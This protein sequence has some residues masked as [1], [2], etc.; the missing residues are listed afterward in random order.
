MES[1][2]QRRRERARQLKRR[3]IADAAVQL[4]LKEGLDAATIEAISESADISPRTFFNYFSTKEDALAMGPSVAVDELVAFV[5]A[6]P[7]EEPA[8]R[9]M[10]ALAKH[11]ADSF[12]PSQ[13]QIAL[14]RRYPQ[15]LARAQSGQKD[16][17]FLA[18]MTAV[19]DREHR[20][21]TADVYPSV[22]VTT[23]FATIQWAVRASWVPEIGKT[24]DELLDAAFD[25]L[26][27]GL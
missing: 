22:L 2:V 6:R 14:W 13:D 23:T 12:V 16:E 20:D 26:E 9:T 4:A 15:L 24:V 5:A 27:R 18:V 3:A 10:R 11:V 8:A 17:L 19:A 7:P 21:L 25:L 1:V